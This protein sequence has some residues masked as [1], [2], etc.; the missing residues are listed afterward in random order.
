MVRQDKFLLALGVFGSRSR[1][2]GRIGALLAHGRT[3][4]PRASLLAVAAASIML[5]ALATA[6]SRSP[7]WIV[8]A[9]QASH[10]FAFEA[11]SVKPH[12]PEDARRPVFQ[13]FPGGRFIA[14]GIPLRFLVAR[15]YDLPPQSMRL[16]G[17]PAWIN[18]QAYDI[19]ASPEASAFPNG[20]PEA[21]RKRRAASI[22]RTLLAD[23]FKLAVHRESTEISAYTL[24]VAKSGHKLHPANVKDKDCNPATG[25]GCQGFSGGQGRGIHGRSVTTAELAAFVENWSDRPVVDRTGLKGSFDM[26]TEG[27]TPLVRNFGKDSEGPDKG[28][29][30]SDPLRPSLFTVLGQLGLQL[31][32]RKTTVDI[33]VIDRLERPDPD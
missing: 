3:V 27:W 5:F 17:G 33:F 25:A 14:I 6:A 26:D 22:L 8:F 13:F 23:R 15:A 21:E 19:E 7:R 2:S 16:T 29:D 24:V 31:E 11:V 9:Q 18:S 32:S 10:V 30:L 12:D 1:L 28:E 4:S 20:L